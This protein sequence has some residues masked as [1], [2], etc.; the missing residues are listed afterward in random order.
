MY[1]ALDIWP[2]I[3]QVNPCACLLSRINQVSGQARRIEVMHGY[4]VKYLR[5]QLLAF[6]VIGPEAA[7]SYKACLEVHLQLT[8]PGLGKSDL[9]FA[10]V[11]YIHFMDIMKGIRQSLVGSRMEDS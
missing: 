3:L 4:V 6:L 10:V 2:C 1:R 11:N 5:P 8:V 9:K 7:G